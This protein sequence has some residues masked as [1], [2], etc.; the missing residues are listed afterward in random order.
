MTDDHAKKLSAAMAECARLQEENKRLKKLLGIP[1]DG[2]PLQHEEDT[3][4]VTNSSPTKEKIALFR[5]L[6]SG[7]EDVYPVR[8]EGKNGRS[9]YSPACSIEWDRALCGKPKVKC[10]ECENRKFLPVT[11]KVIHDHLAGRHTIGVYPLLS[12]ETCRFLAADFDK[13]NW[14]DDISAFLETCSERGVSAALERSRSGEGGHV[15][16]FFENPVSAS[17][18]RKLGCAILTRAMEKRYQI[19]FDSYDRLFPSQDTMPKGGFGNLIALPLQRD[20]RDN[21]NTIFIDKDFRP[22]PDQWRLLSTL[23]KVCPEEVETIVREAAGAGKII[24]VSMSLTEGDSEE[25]PWTL[26]PSGG[27]AEAPI[28]GPLPEAVRVIR[29]NLIYIEKDGLTPAMLNRLMRIAAFQN[30]EFYKAQA[31]PIS[32]RGTLQQYAGRLHRLHENKRVVRIYDY[33]D[34]NVPMLMR[35]YEK[36]LKGY[37][38]M[39]YSVQESFPKTEL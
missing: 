18:A 21:G 1:A 9:G 16:I 26:P 22:Y 19:D 6:F 38:A 15:W 31:M 35:M 29:G 25:D 11:D 20:P 10:G 37:R 24:G 8:W 5:S 12:D 23:K 27:K 7:R 28:E 4:R 34:A 32:W 39:G 2:D 17:S 36:R 3:C 30:P 14:Q 13:A 33:V